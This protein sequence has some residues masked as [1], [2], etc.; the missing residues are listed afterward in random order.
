MTA[1]HLHGGAGYIV[2]HP[3]HH[4]SERAQSLAIRYAPEADALDE[5]AADLLDGP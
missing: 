4:H 5:V 2:E 3:L 1:H